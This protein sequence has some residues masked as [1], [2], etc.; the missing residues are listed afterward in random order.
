MTVAT[1]TNRVTYTG[2]GSTTAFAVS[3]PFYDNTD[4]VVIERVISTGAETTKTLTTHYT[5]S[6]GSGSTGTVTAVT[7]P[8]ST[9]QWIIKRTIPL[10]Q[11]IDYTPNDP[12]PASTH[13]EGLDRAVM[14]DQQIDEEIDRSLKFPSTDSTSLS[15]TLPSSVDRASKYLAFD[16]SGEP[17][18]SPGSAGPSPIPVSAFMETVLDD[19]TAAAARSTLGLGTAAVAATGTSTGNVPLAET[20]FGKQTIWIPAGA[21]TART[22]NGAASGTAETTTNKV[23][24][25]TLDFDTATQEFAQFAIH[26]PKGWNESTVTFQPVWSHAAA[27]TY[28]VVW[29]LEAVALSDDDAADAAFGT[30]QT[31]TDAGGTTNDIYVGPESSAITIGGSPAENDYVVFQIKRNVS[32]GSDTL[33]VDARLHGVKLFYTTNTGVDS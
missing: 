28:G 8:A 27:A 3:F 21:M 25:K 26:M 16:S 20:V 13:E 23:M 6:G 5:V 22:T 14:R 4:L 7:A 2:D 19:E 10:T 30:A 12:F 31:S 17:I 9:V 29:A 33:N 15:A 24:L 11:S 18:A 1:T 32:D